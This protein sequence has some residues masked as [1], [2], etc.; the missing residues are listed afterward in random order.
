EFANTAE[1][2]K[3]TLESLQAQFP[4]EDWGY[5]QN[6]DGSV[7]WSDV[8]L[9]GMSHGATTAAVAGRIGVRLW[10]VVSRSGPRDTTC[11]QAG[12]TC[13]TPLSTPSYDVDCPQDEIAAW[14]DAPSITP[15]NRFYGLVGT[16]DTQCGDIMFD[17]HY[18]GYP[19]EPTIWDVPGAV[20]T[21]T[22]QFFSSGGHLDFLLAAD[23]PM[24]TEE[25]L[26]I[27]FGIPEENRN[28][29]F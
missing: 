4:E 12:G 20:L 15:I 25:V 3:S 18:A 7:R 28:P 6:E 8:A 11:G 9:T 13:S 22:N 2:V 24:N 17:M 14:L 29:N 27:A 26:N 10:R 21:G 5:F 19:G 16:S 23:K 1:H